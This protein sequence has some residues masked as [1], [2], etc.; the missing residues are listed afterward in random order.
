VIEAV[1]ARV[2]T[3]CGHTIVVGRELRLLRQLERRHV[4][5]VRDRFRTSHPLGGLFTALDASPTPWMFVAACDT[6]LLRG[7]LVR[8][9]WR[10]RGGALAVV[11]R[12]SGRLQPFGALYNR[13][14]LP[15]IRK[16]IDAGDFSLQGLLASVET[17]VLPP[18]MLAAAD[19]EGMS[20]RDADTPKAMRRL[21]AL[22]RRAPEGGLS[23]SGKARRARRARMRRGRTD[24]DGIGDHHR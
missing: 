14:C 13:A 3:V 19:P 18:R 1:V 20:F 17:K 22:G 6:P 15:V 2:S 7:A 21:Y 10:S 23:E 9:L 12:V 16:A 8:A 11:A 4:H 24:R 5:L